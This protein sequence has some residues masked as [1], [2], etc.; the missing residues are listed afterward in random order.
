[1]KDKYNQD[2]GHFTHHSKW[3]RLT[4]SEE[5]S[6]H[7][8]APDLTA[9]RDG[10]DEFQAG[11]MWEAHHAWEQGWSTLPQPWRDRVQGAICVAGAV[12]LLDHSRPGGALRV[13]QLARRLLE[14]S[15]SGPTGGPRIANALGALGKAITALET[16]R[17][18]EARRALTGLK[19]RV[20]KPARTPTGASTLLLLGFLAATRVTTAVAD[21]VPPSP[22]PPT[23]P[24]I[25][26][27]SE[28]DR[29]TA[30]TS[31]LDWWPTGES[32]EA[33]ANCRNTVPD[34]AGMRAWLDGDFTAGA[35]LESRTIHGVRLENQP[36]PSLE[37]FEKL[38][39]PRLRD[40]SDQATLTVPDSCHEFH[41]AIEAVFGEQVGERLAYLLARHQLNG[42]HLAGLKYSGA[43]NL[44]SLTSEELD[45]I[46]QS[47]S[48]LPPH[49]LRLEPDLPIVH[50]RRGVDTGGVHANARI[51]LFDKW[52][53]RDRHTRRFVVTHELGHAVG[54]NLDLDRSPTWL[55]HT[56]W[57]ERSRIRPNGTQATVWLPTQPSC[58]VSGYAGENPGEDFAESFLAYRYNP[59]SLLSRCPAKYQFLN[60]LVFNGIEYRTTPACRSPS[61][62]TDQVAIATGPRV[63]ALLASAS[64]TGELDTRG[65]LRT[66]RDSVFD[67]FISGGLGT[68]T[69]SQDAR[70]CLAASI[71]ASVATGPP[72]VGLDGIA[73]RSEF[74]RVMPLFGATLPA[75]EARAAELAQGARARF[76]EHLQS[77]FQRIFDGANSQSDFVYD[78]QPRTPPSDFCESSSQ[79]AS[80]YAE[81]AGT[82]FAMPSTGNDFFFHRH[83]EQY[84]TWMRDACMRVFGSATRLR[85]PSAQVI[86][87]TFDAL[88]ARPAPSAPPAGGSP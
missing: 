4:V 12:W 28:I 59:D 50:Y 81:Q 72:P 19:C 62:L 58:L 7:S 2:C 41:C 80:L 45:D 77:T 39:T 27:Q 73:N 30:V 11:R 44:S 56:G 22:C 57:E 76:R 86:S 52:S 63:D 87:R 67:S 35:P 10:A 6:R 26:S 78:Y 60:E 5:I 64:A 68:T 42:S 51:E 48:E 18:T 21:G 49:L 47:A 85:A 69:L 66:C 79:Y 34:L 23:T 16:D 8:A 29:V 36:T 31:H 43:Q 53:S 32:E 33:A 75:T 24:P 83:R 71:S 61:L 65:P 17:P 1:M 13:A 54:D 3:G 82:T 15:E 55:A 46:I 14:G 88:F 40:G 70:A 38:T 9:W 25:L 74:L 20:E 84:Q 37:L